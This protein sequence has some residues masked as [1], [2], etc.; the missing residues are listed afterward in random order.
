[1]PYRVTSDIVSPEGRRLVFPHGRIIPPPG[2]DDRVNE[3]HRLFQTKAPH[4]YSRVD[5]VLASTAPP[6]DLFAAEQ[7][8]KLL[9]TVTLTTPLLDRRLHASR[10]IG[11]SAKGK[12]NG[13]HLARHSTR[14]CADDNGERRRR[15]SA[16]LGKNCP[17]KEQRG[18]CVVYS[19]W[20][21][22]CMHPPYK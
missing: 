8:R 10:D 7:P 21:L 11:A 18:T 16:V 9:T 19:R 22:G 1:M 6:G 15:S 20:S 2:L 12:R 5:K 3:Q 14:Y 4:P 17:G 13:R